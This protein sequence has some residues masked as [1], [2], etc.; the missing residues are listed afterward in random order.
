MNQPST[1]LAFIDWLRVLA[2]LGVL[3]YHSAR[4]FIPDDPWHINNLEKSNLLDEFNF[5]LSRFRMPLLFSF[6]A[7]LPGIWSKK[8]GRI[9][10]LT[11][12]EKT[13]PAIGSRHAAHYSAPGVYGKK[14]SGLYR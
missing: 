10:H 6:P 8:N 7:Q 11:P 5:F 1:R 3:L 14:T 12:A 2:I 13:V 9:F 4:P